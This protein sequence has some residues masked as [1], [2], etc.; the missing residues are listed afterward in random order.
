MLLP[1]PPTSPNHIKKKLHSRTQSSISTL[2][3]YSSSSNRFFFV[4]RRFKN[5]VVSTLVL[6]VF[7]L[8]CIEI[9][10][11][12]T[13]QQEVREG[14][15]FNLRNLLVTG[16]TT[17]T[18]KTTEEEE[19]SGIMDS[20]GTSRE[21]SEEVRLPI[22]SK[23]LLFKFAGLHGQGSEL[24]TLLRISTLA[25]FYNYTLILDST[26]WNYGPFE[27]YF[28]LFY[29][30][31]P[32]T[33]P[34]R[35]KPSLRC[36]EPNRLK[37]KRVKISLNEN[38]WNNL[39][40]QENSSSWEPDWVKNGAKH[41]VWGLGKRDM[42]GLDQTILKLFVN[43]TKLEQ[44]HLK[45]QSSL[46]RGEG[47]ELGGLEE[48]ESLNFETF[49]EV[50]QR[51]SDEVLKIWRINSEVQEMVENLGRSL[52]IPSRE[53]GGGGGGNQEEKEVGDLV[54]GVHVRLGDK[55]LETDK[56]GPQ[57]Q[58]QSSSSAS[59]IISPY[60][61]S[62]T[63][64]PGLT[65]ST[66]LNY[67][68]ACI[69]SINNLLPPSSLS[70]NPSLAPLL[71]SNSSSREE[72]IEYLLELSK[73]WGTTENENEEK[74]PRLVLMS[75]D[76]ET[77]IKKFKQHPLAIR[78]RILGTNSDDDTP[79]GLVEKEKEVEEERMVKV[80]VNRGKKKKMT[81]RSN[82]H[83]MMMRK[84]QKNRHHLQKLVQQQQSSNSNLMIPGGFNETSFNLLPIS[85]RI[86]QSRKFV[87]DVTF[88]ST[89]CDSL[90]ITASSNVGRLMSLLIGSSSFSRED[91]I[92]AGREGGRGRIRSLDIRWF[93]TAKFN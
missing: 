24:N 18:T 48:E 12:T 72:Q 93:P 74:K 5:W 53:V 9:S 13:N 51:L 37:T 47:K 88:L 54:I 45:D 65:D 83:D 85:N 29:P 46:L 34:S 16:N 69:K 78:F 84:N 31:I 75:D 60:S 4:K 28:Q 21:S 92:E 52:G 49:G 41:V 7:L 80:F 36:R 58:T 42:E 32:L 25:S 30:T 19:D 89:R 66:V 1:S 91:S 76:D 68:A 40:K 20:R 62:Y 81:K 82:V 39:K 17:T 73:H 22:C 87:R 57:V 70:P 15:N 63:S 11:R 59:T 90:I 10:R 56:I 64:T 50:Y 77:V 55:Y 33:F 61:S 23:T 38:D 27:S 2:G 71:S 43:S 79:S 86:S 35:G 3:V 44:L 26:S 67:F 14:G 6:C 8:G